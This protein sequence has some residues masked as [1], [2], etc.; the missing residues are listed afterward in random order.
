MIKLGEIMIMHNVWTWQSTVKCQTC[1]A[2]SQ[3]NGNIV[4][5]EPPGDSVA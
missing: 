4:L 5:P 2:V 1:F 3:I